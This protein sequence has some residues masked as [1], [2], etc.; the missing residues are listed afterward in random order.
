MTRMGSVLGW[1]MPPHIAEATTGALAGAQAGQLLMFA[2]E[3]PVAGNTSAVNWYI[4][5]GGSVSPSNVFCA[6]VNTSGT[7]VAQTANRAADAALT[8]NNSLWSPPWTG[9]PVAVP[10]GEYWACLLIGAE[11]TLPSFICGTARAPVLTNIGCTAGAGN[12]RAA[13]FSSGL[14]ALPGSVTIASM[15]SYIGTIWVA[16]T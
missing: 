4:N 11:V 7:I 14:S 13:T 9:A 3:V 15:V 2:L 6:L 1:S 8:T 12:L 5:T 10:A 16:L